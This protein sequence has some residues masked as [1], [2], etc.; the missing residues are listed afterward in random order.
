[1]LPS[2]REGRTAGRCT[3]TPCLASF[4]LDTEAQREEP[5]VISRPKNASP[6]SPCLGSAALASSQSVL[7][8]LRV[9]AASGKSPGN[10]FVLTPPLPSTSPDHSG[11]GP[12][13]R[14]A[15]THMPLPKATLS[16]PTHLKV[17]AGHE[18]VTHRPTGPCSRSGLGRG[19]AS[20]SRGPSNRGSSSV[21]G[22]HGS[23]S[24]V[25]AAP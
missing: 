17:R 23:H 8:G 10:S 4:L 15:G 24:R 2:L 14:P 1:M 7:K 18:V 16:M 20:A 21:L 19:G 6:G 12:R 22:G 11:S 3:P 25:I 13:L 5:Q 9:Q